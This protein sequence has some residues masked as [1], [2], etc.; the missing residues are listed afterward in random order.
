MLYWT[1]NL[2]QRKATNNYGSLKNC[3][4]PDMTTGVRAHIQHLKA[5]AKETP[6]KDIVD[7]RFKAAFDRGSSGINFG[8]VCS[9]WSENPSYGKKIEEILNNLNS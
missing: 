7:P 8:Q 3:S 4:F 1:N 5:Y 6:K 2:K 9:I